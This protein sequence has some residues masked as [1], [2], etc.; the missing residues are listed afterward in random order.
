LT[1]KE[2][3]SGLCYYLG[4]TD[5]DTYCKGFGRLLLS[6]GS[7]FIGDFQMQMMIKGKLFELQPN[8]SYT[9]FE[10]EYNFQEDIKKGLNTNKQVPSQKKLI[11]EGHTNLI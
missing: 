11:S 2:D 8:G 9:M 6:N 5:K 10:V 1:K 3:V 4:K 7:V